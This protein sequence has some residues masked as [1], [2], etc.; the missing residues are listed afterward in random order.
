MSVQG[1]LKTI[2]KDFIDEVLIISDMFD[3]NELVSFDLL[4]S[5]MK[6]KLHIR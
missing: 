2:D 1:N 3:L 4:V 5:G 6:K